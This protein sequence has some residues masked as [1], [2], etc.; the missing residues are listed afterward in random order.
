MDEPSQQQRAKRYEGIHN[1]LFVAETCYT[2]LL[3]VAFLYLGGSDTLANVARSVSPNPWIH[4]A[5]YGAVVVSAT[6][7]L[8]LADSY[9]QIVHQ[10]AAEMTATIATLTT[11]SCLA[12]P[13][14]TPLRM[15]YPVPPWAAD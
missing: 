15:R 12:V 2:L 1:V 9:R 14:R 4:V 5:I 3:L 6:K 11:A 10:M 8:L 13:R 7:L